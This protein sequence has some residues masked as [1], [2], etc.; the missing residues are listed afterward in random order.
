M[1]NLQYF[2]LQIQRVSS[3][4]IAILQEK[5]DWITSQRILISEITKVLVI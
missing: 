2:F 3:T 1:N 5:D 4:Q